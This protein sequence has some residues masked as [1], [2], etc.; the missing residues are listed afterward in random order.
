MHI[1]EKAKFRFEAVKEQTKNTYI[2]CTYKI[3]TK[4]FYTY[5]FACIFTYLLE[6]NV[7]EICTCV[8]EQH[9]GFISLLALR[10][11]ITQK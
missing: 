4:G 1:N 9:Q 8:S 11:F 3:R 10:S 5:T 2:Y 7:C 6:C